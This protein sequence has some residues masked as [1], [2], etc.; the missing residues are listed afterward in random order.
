MGAVA[1]LCNNMVQYVAW[2]GYIEAAA[3]AQE[4]GLERDKFNEI[5]SW[6]MN[7]NARA[8]LASRTV[9]EQEP[10]HGPLL[11]ALGAAMKLAEKD[12]TLALAVGR[13][14]GV[15]LPGTALASQEVGRLFAIPDPKRR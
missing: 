3:M 10:D 2:Q 8:F 14:A 12:L 13:D 15:A 5:L 11:A 7:D 9:L 6:L 1:K 4:A